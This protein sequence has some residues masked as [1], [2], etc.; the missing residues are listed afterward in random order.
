MKRAF[1]LVELTVVLTV[2]AILTHLAVRELGS[3]RDRKLAKAADGQLDTI[4]T[5]SAAFLSDVGRL[6]R[7]T[8]AT[9]GDEEVRTLSELWMRPDDLPPSAV[10]NLDGV[11]VRAGWRGPYL[12]LPFGKTRLFD[13]WG[14]PIESRDAAGLVRLWA[15]N[16]IVTNVCHYGPSAQARDRRD[17]SLVPDGG[18]AQSVVVNVWSDREAGACKVTCYSPVE[19]VVTAKT[20]DGTIGTPIEL[21][22]VTPGERLIR[23]TCASGAAAARFVNVGLGMGAV[24]IRLP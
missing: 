3:L 22:N 1:T 9:N 2:I 5:A 19:G 8:V 11:A 13:P 17:R 7:W 16:S 18:A 10:T 12:R 23:A 20:V 6:P 4:R 15:T 24:E 21:K 14:N